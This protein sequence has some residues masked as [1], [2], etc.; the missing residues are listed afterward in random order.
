[1]KLKKLL[2]EFLEP[3]ATSKDIFGK[4]LFAPER[5]E[6]EEYHIEGV[7]EP[8][9]KDEKAFKK[10][11]LSFYEDNEPKKLLAYA[12]KILEL[13]KSTSILDFLIPANIEYTEEWQYQ[14]SF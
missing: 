8:N 3:E 1:M 2:F 12:P 6:T 4:Y 7:D 5:A 10:A 11:L 9:T 14:K 13:L